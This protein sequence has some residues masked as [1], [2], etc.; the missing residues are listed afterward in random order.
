MYG[1]V[2]RYFQNRGYGFIYGEDSNTYFIHYSNLQ[3]EYLDSGYYVHF[4]PFQNDRSDYNAKNVIVINAPERKGK[5][6]NSTKNKKNHR[7]HRACNADKITRDNKK[8]QKF[9]KNFLCE[10]KV[11]NEERGNDGKNNYK[12]E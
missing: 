11:L 1:R 3:G 7:K 4:T 12:Y 9:V 5:E 6:K 2:T 8:F 10:Q